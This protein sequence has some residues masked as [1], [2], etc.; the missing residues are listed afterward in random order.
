MVKLISE[1]VGEVI[2]IDYESLVGLAHS[3]RVKVKVEINKPLI[4][5]IHLDLG[6]SKLA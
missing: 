1:R 4:N 5:G 6:N 3:I 2:E